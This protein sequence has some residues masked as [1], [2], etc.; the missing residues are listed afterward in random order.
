MDGDEQQMVTKPTMMRTIKSVEKELNDISNE[1]RVA[2][3]RGEIKEK[4]I[5]EGAMIPDLHPLARR[6]LELFNELQTIRMTKN[7]RNA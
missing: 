6:Q 2:F 1:L 3:E 5:K 4:S 7:K